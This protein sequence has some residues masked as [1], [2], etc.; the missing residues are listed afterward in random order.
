MVLELLARAKK[1]QKEI[2]K[3]E[4]KS[5]LFV[6]DMILYLK[7]CKDST[8]NFYSLLTVFGKLEEYKITIQK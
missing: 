5:I 7:D 8:K 2:G 6:H 3:E 1:Q 4:V